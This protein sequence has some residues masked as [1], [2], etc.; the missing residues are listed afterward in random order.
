MKKKGSASLFFRILIVTTIIWVLVLAATMAITLQISISNQ[1]E[2]N[3][4]TLKAVATALSE[5]SIVINSLK[6]GKCPDYFV[7]F[8]DSFITKSP[9]MDIVTIANTDSIRLYHIVHSRIGEVFVGGD[10]GDCLEGKSY[11]SDAVG[12]LGMQRRYFSP[13]WDFGSKS[14]NGKVI[15]FV[16]AS[17]TSRQTKE[18]YRET[19]KAYAGLA[20]ILT[21]ISIILSSVSALFVRKILLGFSPLDLVHSYLK[22]NEVLNTLTEGVILVDREGK[23]QLTNSACEKM[24]GHPSDYLVNR[25]LDTFIQSIKGNSLVGETL[26]NF[27]TNR[28]NLLA[29]SIPIHSGISRE[30]TQNKNQRKNS[31]GNSGKYG[32][33][34]SSGTTIILT[35]RSEAMRNAEQLNGTRHIISAL[36]A[37]SHEFMNKLQVLSGLLQMNK[38]KEAQEY[39]NNVSAIHSQALTPFLHLIA[40]ASVCALLLGKLNNAREMDIEVKLLPNSKLPRHSPYLTTTELITIIGNLFENAIEAINAQPAGKPRNITL[41]ITE[42]DSGLLIMF[43]DTGIGMADD[44]IEHI[45]EEGFSTKGK[46]GRGIG[47]NLVQKLVDRNHGTIEIDSDPGFGT[48]FTIIFHEKNREL[49]FDAY[50]NN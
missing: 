41:Q 49:N 47:M 33:K 12:T 19:R 20:I 34:N 36:R 44:I 45:F 29:T 17:T 39:I 37:N 7:G 28:Q 46:E 8:L 23:I 5:N 30:N 13:V 2:K 4:A 24:L 11:F 25:T 16:M 10:Q 48:T 38:T 1:Q 31:G 6:Q 15:G 35:D 43:S 14:I 42:D 9:T 26:N 3:D 21:L 22:Q 18:L 32:T 27:P 50:N 40:N